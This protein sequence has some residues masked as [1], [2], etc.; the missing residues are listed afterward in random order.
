MVQNL[1][2]LECWLKQLKH[3]TSDVKRHVKVSAGAQ[4]TIYSASASEKNCLLSSFLHWQA[5]FLSC[6]IGTWSIKLPVKMSSS[7]I[8]S[9]GFESQLH[10]LKETLRGNSK[11]CSS[12]WVSAIHVGDLDWIPTMAIE[13]HSC[14]WIQERVGFSPHPYLLCFSLAFPNK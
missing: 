3:F 4:H 9:P 10:S 6:T 14:T 13:G 11:Q 7:Y 12:S 8:G 1:K 2:L 5:V